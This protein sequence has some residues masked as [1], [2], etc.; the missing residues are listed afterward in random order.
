MIN[1]IYLFNNKNYKYFKYYIININN[2]LYS[3]NIPLS[4]KT[5]DDKSISIYVELLDNDYMLDIVNCKK[6][7]LNDFFINCDHF[8]AE[9]FKMNKYVKL[10]FSDLQTNKTYFETNIQSLLLKEKR[11]IKMNYVL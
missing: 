2:I 3:I 11:K 6:I 10:L 4:F 8:F 9:L 7:T 5:Y 1:S